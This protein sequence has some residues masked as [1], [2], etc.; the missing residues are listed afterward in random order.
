VEEEVLAVLGIDDTVAVAVAVVVEEGM[1]ANDDSRTEVD[2]V[3]SGSPVH[4]TRG[5]HASNQSVAV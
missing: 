2:E 4:S 3:R 1:N 5:S